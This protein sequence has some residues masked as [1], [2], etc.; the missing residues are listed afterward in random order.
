MKLP[1]R[2]DSHI[3]NSLPMQVIIKVSGT[4]QASSLTKATLT[5][6]QHATGPYYYCTWTWFFGR[7]NRKYEVASG[8]NHPT[9]QLRRSGGVLLPLRRVHH[10]QDV[11]GD[12]PGQP[13]GVLI[14]WSMDDD[15]EVRASSPAIPV[16]ILTGLMRAR[17]DPLLTSNNQHLLLTP[18]LSLEDR[19]K[20]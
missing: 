5:Q 1:L 18:P 12:R 13:A 7:R 10:H 19:V 8:R 11:T 4:G 20:N 6:G 14:P 16:Q 3:Q 15:G 17:Y 2:L 9:N